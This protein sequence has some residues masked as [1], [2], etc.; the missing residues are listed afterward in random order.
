VI[1]LTAKTLVD[2]QVR[3]LHDGA[4]AYV[5][6]PFDPEYLLALI[7]S[8]L[9]NQ[10]NLRDALEH[11]TQTDNIDS[12]I[13]SSSD[14]SFMRELY[15]LMENKMSDNELN[16]TRITEEMHISRT[17][18][19]YKMNGLT[20][21]TPNEFF[22]TYKLNRAAELILEG[23]YNIS[24]IADITGFSTLSHFSVSFKKHFGI[25]PSDYLKVKG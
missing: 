21:M 16:V 13:I 5:T 23:K 18:F 15:A 14:T 17:K 7:Q 3:G 20:G 2:D 24:E 11:A 25:S 12:S 19:Y 22:K 1:L 8:Q 6:K 9:Q 4:N 10:K